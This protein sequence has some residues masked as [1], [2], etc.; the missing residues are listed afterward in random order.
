[1]EEGEEEKKQP[2]DGDLE[3]LTTEVGGNS[4]TEEKENSAPDDA[5]DNLEEVVTTDC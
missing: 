2:A 1:M 3:F 4:K 5:G